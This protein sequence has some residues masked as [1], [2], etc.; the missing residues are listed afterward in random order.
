MN[1]VSAAP[2]ARQWSFGW[3]NDHPIR[4]NCDR[5]DG[6][7]CGHWRHT[8]ILEMR[9][10]TPG[11]AEPSAII[12]VFACDL[13]DHPRYTDNCEAELFYGVCLLPRDS[14]IN[15]YAASTHVDPEMYEYGVR[16]LGVDIADMPDVFV[17]MYGG[18]AACYFSSLSQFIY[19]CG[20]TIGFTD[21]H[22]V[23]RNVRARSCLSTTECLVQEEIDAAKEKAEADVIYVL[24]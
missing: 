18:E 17:N 24:K 23:V 3:K 16:K 15:I 20:E 19:D 10:F 13:D 14:T 22:E 21:A 2:N 12:L 1:V 7:P 9:G 5:P 8:T 11:E 4:C 6:R